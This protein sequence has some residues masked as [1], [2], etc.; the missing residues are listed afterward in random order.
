M[1]FTG[2][3]LTSGQTE[4]LHLHLDNVDG[5]SRDHVQ[6]LLLSAHVG[7]AQGSSQ[8]VQTVVVVH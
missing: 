5:Q 6:G 4:R 7:E 2:S 3:K 1:C 8:V